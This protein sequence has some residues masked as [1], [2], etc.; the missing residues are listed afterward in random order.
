MVVQIKAFVPI[1]V[2]RLLAHRRRLG[3]LSVDGRDGK[4]VG[5][6]YCCYCLAES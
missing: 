6:A 1:R 2:E 3:L 4:G 5:E